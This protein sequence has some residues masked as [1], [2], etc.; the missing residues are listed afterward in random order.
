[1]IKG[2]EEALMSKVE[3]EATNALE[4]KMKENG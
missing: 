1:L 2:K 4:E 3:G